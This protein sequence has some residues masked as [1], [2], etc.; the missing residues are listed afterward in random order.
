MSE[1][2]LEILTISQDGGHQSFDINDTVATAELRTAAFIFR[3]TSRAKASQNGR[4]TCDRPF[5]SSF[6]SLWPSRNCS[7]FSK[8][9]GLL[10]IPLSM[11]IESEFMSPV[12]LIIIIR[13]GG[14]D[15][16]LHKETSKV[17]SGSHSEGRVGRMATE[18]GHFAP[19]PKYKQRKVCAVRDFPPG[20]GRL[21]APITIPSEQAQGQVVSESGNPA[22]LSDRVDKVEPERVFEISGLQEDLRKENVA[23]SKEKVVTQISMNSHPGESSLENTLTRNYCPRRGVT[24]VRDFPPFCG[25]NAPCLSEEER[26]KWLASLKNKG[27]NTEK[28]VNEEKPL[29]KTICT[30]VK[31]VIEDVQDVISLEGKIE[32]SA[33]RLS[34]EELQSKPEDLASKKMRKQGVYEASSRDMEDAEDMGEN[35]IKSCCETFPN[36]F[37]SKSKKV[38]E[39]RDGYIRGLEENPIRDIVVYEEVNSFEKKLSDSSA[40][41]D[42][43]LEENRGSQEVLSDSSIVQGLMASST[44]PWQQGKVTCKSDLAGGSFK[45]KKKNNFTLLPRADAKKSSSSNK[46]ARQDLSQVVIWNKEDSFQQDGQHT[47]DNFARR[48]YSYDVSLPPCPSTMGHDNEAM[49]SRNKVRETLRLF[50]AV[51]RKLLQE[52]E[53]KLKEQG[54]T[55]KRVDCQAAKILKEKGKY[56]NTGKQIIGPVPGVEVGDEFQYF[57]EL[58]IV[59]LHRQSQ[60]GIDYVKQGEKIIATSIIASGGYEDDLDNSDV[61]SY[62]GQGGNV[63]QKGKQ[64]EDQKLER[65]NLALAN[66]RFVKNP[67]RVIRGETRS[68]DL[69]EGRGKTYVYDGLYLVEE[70]K[71]EPGPHGKLVYKFKLVRIQGQPELAWK[72]VKKSKLREGLCV[73][74]ISQRKEIIPICAINT[75]DSEK[76]P[77]F[78]YEP[79]MIYPDWCRP[80]R[81]KGCG[82]ING[83]SQSGKC[84]CVMRN[85]GEIPYNHNGAIVEAKPIVYECGPTCNCPAKCNNRVSQHGIKFQLEIFKTESR[86]WGVRSLNSI[87]SGSFICEYAGELLEDREAEERT[88]NDEYLFDIGN[89]YSDS[90]LWDGLSTLMPDAHSSSCQVLPDSGF[91]IDAARCGNIGRFINHSCSPNLYAQNVLYDHDDRRIPHIMF[92]AAENVPP[93]QELTYHYNYMIDQ[94]RDENGNIKKKICHCG[95]S[96]CTGRLY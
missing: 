88:G 76:P 83:C 68:S 15:N 78:V 42:L 71:Q 25:R 20:C 91:T 14:F 10:F 16:M 40:F 19:V 93:L 37:D 47:N 90:S 45:K 48:S 17:A 52:E 24:V 50:Q 7:V 84:S 11:N 72:V 56:V 53:S 6:I 59:G 1:A 12:W 69:S 64:P 26:M 23:A 85:G 49:T 30:N 33:T 94:V 34:A 89:N 5:L 82:C 55:H 31:Q 29:E 66:S 32:C 92:F 58:N 21:A 39:T 2:H 27:F 43:W 9:F 38:T 73:H 22:L 74:D 79:H 4:K 41:E 80:I 81:P 70:F 77:L 44:C 28:F 95:S 51:C 62:M 65:G 60:G 63:M 35:S 75:I 18:N 87:P 8:I 54:K 57:V 86:G 46:R 61:L 36:E 67:V 3:Q 96:E 13:N